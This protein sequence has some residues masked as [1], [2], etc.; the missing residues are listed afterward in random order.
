MQ[1]CFVILFTDHSLRDLILQVALCTHLSVLC[2]IVLLLL[3]KNYVFP[4]FRRKTS[5]CQRS[6]LRLRRGQ[7]FRRGLC[8]RNPRQRGLTSAPLDSPRQ[9]DAGPN[10]RR[11]FLLSVT[12][13]PRNCRSGD[14]Y[15]SLFDRLSGALRHRFSFCK[16]HLHNKRGKQAQPLQRSTRGAGG[17]PL[18]VKI[19]IAL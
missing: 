18:L 12:L 4:L 16:P 1:Y 15:R 9:R 17:S 14:G 8:P 6:R 7:T 3:S 2:T 5:D 10:P 19:T 13:R 11:K